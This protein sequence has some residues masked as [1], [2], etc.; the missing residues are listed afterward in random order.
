MIRTEAE[1]LD[2][3]LDLIARRIGDKKRSARMK[4]KSSPEGFTLLVN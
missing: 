4:K 3:A 2:E 1:T